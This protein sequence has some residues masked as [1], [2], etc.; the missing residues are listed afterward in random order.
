[1]GELLNGRQKPDAIFAS[2]DKLT[3]GCFRIL[4]TRG[5]VV[6]D[7]MGLIGYSNSE[8]TE[9]LDPPLSIIQQPAF[10]MGELATGLLLQLIESKRPVKDFETKVLLTELLIRGSTKKKKSKEKEM[11]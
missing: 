2:A 3:T 6:P 8:L 11:V 7:D 9:L 10:E 1:M 4:K 5:F